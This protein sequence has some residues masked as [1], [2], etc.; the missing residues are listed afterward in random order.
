MF[1]IQLINHFIQLPYVSFNGIEIIQGQL[2]TLEI[3]RDSFMH[4][5]LQSQ[6]EYQRKVIC[7]FQNNSNSTVGLLWCY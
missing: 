1:R 5:L 6:M 3:F 7:L 4:Y 2:V